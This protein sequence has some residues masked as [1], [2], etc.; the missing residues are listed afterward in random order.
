MLTI[1][2]CSLYLFLGGGMYR[3]RRYACVLQMLGSSLDWIALFHLT[4]IETGLL[5]GL[6]RLV[7]QCLPPRHKLQL[8]AYM[9][10]RNPKSFLCVCTAS[11]LLT[12]PSILPI[13]RI[14]LPRL[15]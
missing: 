14:P 2:N 7:G 8:P 4:F 13:P 11:S 1:L 9:G 15:S 5:T 10:A 3:V 6:T 12:E